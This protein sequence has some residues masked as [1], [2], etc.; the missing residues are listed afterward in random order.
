MFNKEEWQ[1]VQRWPNWPESDMCLNWF[2]FN[3][4][5]KI[6]KKFHL[7]REKL[8]ANKCNKKAKNAQLC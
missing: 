2:D 3:E 5:G 7:V 4:L 8:K 6:F 1:I